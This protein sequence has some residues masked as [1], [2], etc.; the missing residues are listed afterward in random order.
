MKD[1]IQI[2]SDFCSTVFTE[3]DLSLKEVL[4]NAECEDNLQFPALLALV[5]ARLKLTPENLKDVD[6]FIRYYVRSN[7]TYYVSRGA[8]GGIQRAEVHQRKLAAAAT[9]EAA[10]KQVIHQID[11]KLAA[12]PPIDANEANAACTVE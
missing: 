11:D 10:K 4:P 3:T 7:P 6:P 8:K 5:G 2:A 9:K 1:C 12:P